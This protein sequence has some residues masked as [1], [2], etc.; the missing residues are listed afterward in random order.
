MLPFPLLLA[1]DYRR[2][3]NFSLGLRLPA[4]GAAEMAEAF[5]GAS[6]RTIEAI[7]PYI[8]QSIVAPKPGSG[9]SEAIVPGVTNGK[10]V[11]VAR[12][13]K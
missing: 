13:R 2:P 12:L 3:S 9:R 1:L 4:P 6:A 10:R 8:A 7:A 5:G 11:F